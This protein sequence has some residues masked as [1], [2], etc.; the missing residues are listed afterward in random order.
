MVGFDIPFAFVAAGALNWRANGERTDL[1][2]LYTGTGVAVPGLAFVEKYPDWDWQYFVDP[3]TLP[4]GAPAMFL[5][6]VMLSGWAGAKAGA[7]C[8]KWILGVAG[9]LVVFVGVTLPRTL[10]V[11]TYAEYMAGEAPLISTDWLV[12][13]IPWFLIAGIM[14]GVCLWPIEKARK[15]AAT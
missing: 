9:L 15:A 8:P 3:N 1:A 14:L 4:V 12:F 6:A 7:C 2:M 13:G 5:L 11:G 10:H